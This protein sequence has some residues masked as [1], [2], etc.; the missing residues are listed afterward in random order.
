MCKVPEEGRSVFNFFP[1]GLE[2][3][4]CSRSQMGWQV[5]VRGWHKVKLEKKQ[6]TTQGLTVKDFGLQK[7]TQGAMGV[8]EG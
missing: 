3:G 6:E 4:L 2:E 1:T 7:N 8:I 5:W